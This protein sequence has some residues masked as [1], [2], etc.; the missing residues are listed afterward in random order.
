MDMN[1]HYEEM[2]D[3]LQRLIGEPSSLL[4]REQI[5]F[6]SEPRLYSD[7]KLLNHR[8]RSRYKPIQEMLYQDACETY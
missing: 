8:L 2:L 7:D 1:V 5:V 3:F 6:P 4:D